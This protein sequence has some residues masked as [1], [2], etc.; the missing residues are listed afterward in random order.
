M[1]KQMKRNKICFGL[2]TVGRDALYSLISMFLINHLTGVVGFSDQGLITIGAILTILGIFD[3]VIDPFMGIL[4]DNTSTK[5]GRYKPW[6]FGGMIGMGLLSICMFHNIRMDETTHIITLVIIYFLF[7][8][9]FSFPLPAK[10]PKQKS[11]PYL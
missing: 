4:V 10:V 9:T 1:D 5:F 8:V 6:I 3:A 2:G 11:S 7:S